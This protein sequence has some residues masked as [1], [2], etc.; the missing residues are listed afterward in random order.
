MK[1]KGMQ[2]SAYE[3]HQDI[4]VRKEKKEDRKNNRILWKRPKGGQ[5]SGFR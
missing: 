3:Q 5:R 4:G 1:V 2:R